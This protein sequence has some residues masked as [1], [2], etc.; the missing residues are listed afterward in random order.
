MQ[1]TSSA[2]PADRVVASVSGTAYGE[3]LAHVPE[4]RWLEGHI[5][6]GRIRLRDSGLRTLCALPIRRASW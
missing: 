3:D 5:G 2:R 6:V 4:M 1:A